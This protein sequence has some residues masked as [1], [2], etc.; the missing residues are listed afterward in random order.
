[1]SRLQKERLPIEDRPLQEKRVDPD[2]PQFVK[3]LPPFG[4]WSGE[5]RVRQLEK[6]ALQSQARSLCLWI[7]HHECRS[8]DQDC[9][10]AANPR[11]HLWDFHS[12]PRNDSDR[13]DHTRSRQRIVGSVSE[14][15]QK[16]YRISRSMVFV[17]VEK[18]T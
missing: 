10:P 5:L 17:F 3:Q 11:A 4:D 18:A 7:R 15:R 6:S 14:T 16:L 2:C 13:E 1:M 12:K 8:E 9:A